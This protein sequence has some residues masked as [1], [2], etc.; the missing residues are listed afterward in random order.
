[1]TSATVEETPLS[2]EIGQEYLDQYRRPTEAL[3]N[4]PQDLLPEVILTMIW[5]LHP[6]CRST[7]SDID[8]AIAAR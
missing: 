5:K 4:V 1:M 3:R 2:I 7:L 8:V 6:E